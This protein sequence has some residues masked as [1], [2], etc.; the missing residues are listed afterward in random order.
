MTSHTSLAEELRSV[1]DSPGK[2]ALYVGVLESV[3]NNIGTDQA[4]GELH[5]Q[6]LEICSLAGQAFPST[7]P[8]PE[9]IKGN[10]C[11]PLLM[12]F[13]LQALQSY[14]VQVEEHPGAGTTKRRE[15]LSLAFWAGG[16]Q[17]GGNR[18]SRPWTV[19]QRME[20]LGRFVS[21]LY[22]HQP[23]GVPSGSVMEKAFLE[24][25]DFV[26]NADTLDGRDDKAITENRRRL[27]ELLAQHG[28]QVEHFKL[29]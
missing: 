10:A 3:L 13:L 26:F 6:F 9:E 28:Y 20:I 21:S 16:G 27:A 12:T 2:G 1:M 24:T 25:Y 14:R 5:Q 22:R 11:T 17:R 7:S 8:T 29:T 19:S 18:R 23:E 15:F 4:D